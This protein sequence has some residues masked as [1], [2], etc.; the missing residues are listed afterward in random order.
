MQE[1]KT[2]ELAGVVTKQLQLLGEDPSRDGLVRTPL[3]VAQALFDLTA[4]YRQTRRAGGGGGKGSPGG[5]E[6]GGGGA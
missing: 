5:P 1:S 6:L 2:I 3:R 4:G